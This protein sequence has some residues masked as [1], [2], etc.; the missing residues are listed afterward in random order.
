MTKSSQKSLTFVCTQKIFQ[1][2]IFK[3]LTAIKFIGIQWKSINTIKD[4]LMGVNIYLP[5]IGN[6]QD[7]T[8]SLMTIKTTTKTGRNK[9]FN[10]KLREERVE[11]I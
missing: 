6:Q 2:I 9:K 7:I 1:K 4:A 5:Y 8:I 3:F 11:T 10:R